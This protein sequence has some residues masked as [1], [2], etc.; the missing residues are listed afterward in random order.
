MY[1]IFCDMHIFLYNAVSI[2]YNYNKPENKKKTEK[3]KTAKNNTK[4]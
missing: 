1:Q 4:G 2:F 3:A